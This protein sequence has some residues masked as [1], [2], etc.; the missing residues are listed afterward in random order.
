[1]KWFDYQTVYSVMNATSRG[2]SALHHIFYEMPPIL[3]AEWTRCVRL[4]RL[5][6][7]DN[8]RTWKQNL[9][10]SRSL[11]PCSQHPVL[12]VVQPYHLSKVR[13]PWNELNNNKTYVFLGCLLL[14]PVT[15]FA[16]SAGR[17]IPML[18]I[19]CLFNTNSKLNLNMQIRL[20][21]QFNF[22]QY[23]CMPPEV[24]LKKDWFRYG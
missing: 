18:S 23:L 14:V 8:F 13:P 4:T 9:L 19:T 12:W 5:K 16:L 22:E 7:P 1:M 11:T 21:A 6:V 15:L 3:S 17:Q 20:H 2:F 24:W 10:F